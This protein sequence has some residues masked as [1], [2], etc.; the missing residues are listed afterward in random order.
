M[1]EYNDL[2][3]DP[4]ILQ[5]LDM[6]L[7]KPNTERNYLMGLQK[8]LDFTG[9]SPDALLDEAEDEAAKQVRPRKSRFLQ[10]LIAYQKY[11]EQSDYAATSKRLFMAAV[12][13]FYQSAYIP[14]PKL[15]GLQSSE[16]KEEN[17]KLI[18]K[19]DIRVTLKV[20][21]PLE[22]VIVLW[23]FLPDLQRQT[24]KPQGKDFTNYLSIH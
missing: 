4:T 13:S 23:G 22:R 18:T 1:S 7:K 12:K 17:G 15:H 16:P 20:C 19:E 10:R 8:Y 9:M 5:W 2:R 3:Q 24:N 14:I 21:D 6:I 11:L